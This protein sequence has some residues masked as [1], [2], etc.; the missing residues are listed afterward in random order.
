MG[1]G[2]KGSGQWNEEGLRTVI[3]GDGGGNVGRRSGGGW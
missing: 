1:I 2:R 3:R